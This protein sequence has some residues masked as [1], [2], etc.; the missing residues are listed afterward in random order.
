MV[1]I[2]RLYNGHD[3]RGLV[4]LSIDKLVQDANALKNLYYEPC[5]QTVHAKSD[6]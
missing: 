3:K 4:G 1:N 6:D 5:G 2:V